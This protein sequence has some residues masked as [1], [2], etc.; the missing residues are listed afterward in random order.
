MYI[1]RHSTWNKWGS[2]LSNSLEYILS[3]NVNTNKR[4]QF[5]LT[6]DDVS[7][8]H[9]ET[10]RLPPK[11]TMPKYMDALFIHELNWHK[12]RYNYFDSL[13]SVCFGCFNQSWS[14][15]LQRR[16]T[17][18]WESFYLPGVSWFQG[19]LVQ[20]EETL[21]QAVWARLTEWKL[22]RKAFTY[23]NEKKAFCFSYHI[24]VVFS[25]QRLKC[26]LVILPV[27]PH[28]NLCYILV[29]ELSIGFS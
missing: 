5:V 22:P 6:F 19:Y 7:W 10:P 4:R 26:Y 13:L 18:L 14:P 28:I 12:S 27:T 11:K 2:L 9:R 24:T 20:K 1:S 29:S 25:S 16:G 23:L 15:R 17:V 8:Q 21:P 3:R